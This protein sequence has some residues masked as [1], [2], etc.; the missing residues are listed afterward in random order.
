MDV[1]G[2]VEQVGDVSEGWLGK[3]VV[4]L[5]VMATGSGILKSPNHLWCLPEL[6]RTYPDARVIWTHR[7]PAKLV[8]SLAS[9]NSAMQIQFAREFDARRL[10]EYWAS[11]V[12]TA[13][14]SAAAFDESANDDWCCHV[15]YRE[16]MA[17]PQA[18]LEKIYA[19]F[20]ETVSPLH[21][22]RMDTWLRQRSQHS[23][24][25]HSYQAGDF[26]WTADALQQRYKQYRERYTVPT[27]DE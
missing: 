25:I 12:D 20:G 2:T 4:A 13:I 10:G 23:E 27:E 22:Q 18:T 16:L 7:D 5:T 11:K 9:L 19:H 15:Q 1:R 26:G 24:G 21:R 3:R 6:L 8:P 14:S 17:R